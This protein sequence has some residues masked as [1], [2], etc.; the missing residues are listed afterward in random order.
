MS[1]K[2]LLDA[3]VFIEARDRYYGFELCPGFWAALIRYHNQKQVFSIDQIKDELVKQEDNIKQWV[4]TEAPDDFFKKAQ[5]K[6]VIDT[7]QQMVR[8]VSGKSQFS[9]QAK[10]EFASVADGWLVAYAHVNGL[11][12]VTHEVYRPD[13]KRKVLIPNVCEEFDVEYLNAFEMLGELKVKFVLSPK[14]QK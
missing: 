14:R 5:D 11:I 10:A 7:F 9:D 1:R 6:N 3:N 13:A 8:W 2:F 4:N 12:V